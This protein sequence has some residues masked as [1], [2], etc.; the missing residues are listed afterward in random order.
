MRTQ[1]VAEPK[2]GRK[3]EP[4]PEKEMGEHMQSLVFGVRNGV[5]DSVI[6]PGLW[7][8]RR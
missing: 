8:G 2:G 1:V 3:P 4:S 5:A 7:E 6:D